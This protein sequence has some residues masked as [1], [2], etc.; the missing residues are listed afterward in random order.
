MRLVLQH[1]A[2]SSQMQ[3]HLLFHLQESPILIQVEYLLYLQGKVTQQHTR[4]LTFQNQQLPYQFQY[5]RERLRDQ[6][7]LQLLLSM[8]RC[9]PTNNFFLGMYFKMILFFPF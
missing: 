9:F 4:R 7:C 1:L 5:C 8:L 2:S 3:K 6:F